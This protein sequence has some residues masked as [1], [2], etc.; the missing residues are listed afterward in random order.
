M[1]IRLTA[2]AALV[3]SASATASAHAEDF[4]ASCAALAQ[5]FS[6]SGRVVTAEFVAAGGVQLA[7][8]G[9]RVCSWFL[10]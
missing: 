5:G 2:P 6:G 3:L 8:P 7:P 1:Q 4:E 10:A 9:S